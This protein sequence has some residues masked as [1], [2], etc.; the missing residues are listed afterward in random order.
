[1]VNLPQQL[2][3]PPGQPQPPSQVLPDGQQQLGQQQHQQP[4]EQQ[5][6]PLDQQ[7]PEQQQQQQ[8]QPPLHPGALHPRR[9]PSRPQTAIEQ[10]KLLTLAASATNDTAQVKKLPEI[11]PRFHASVLSLAIADELHITRTACRAI[12][13]VSHHRHLFSISRTHIADIRLPSG[14]SLCRRCHPQGHYVPY[15]QLGTAARLTSAPK[16]HDNLIAALLL[17]SNQPLDRAGELDIAIS[18]WMAARDTVAKLTCA[19]HV[20]TDWHAAFTYGVAE[21]EMAAAHPAHD[22]GTQNQAHTNLV[23]AEFLARRSHKEIMQ[24]YRHSQP[25]RRSAPAD[26]LGLPRKCARTGHLPAAC[27]AASTVTGRATASLSNDARSPHALAAPSGR[28]YCFSSSFALHST[29]CDDNMYTY[30]HG[31][32]ICGAAGHAPA[33]RLGILADWGHVVQGLR[34]G[35]DVG[36]KEQ[37]RSTTLFTNHSSTLDAAFIDSYIVGEQAAGRYSHAFDPAELE[38]LIG[39]YRTAPLG[40]VPKPHSNKFHLIQDLSFPRH[41]PFATSV[42]A[43]VNANSFPTAWGTFNDVSALLLSLPAGCMAATFDIAA[44]YPITP[45]APS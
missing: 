26:H 28:L 3:L 37:P 24:Q 42:N 41:D 2:N 11:I 10:A 1:M 9:T 34:V 14:S 32:S 17:S 15:H 4:L 18:E 16:D 38:Q 33:S 44:A 30:F 8:Q 25:G 5:Q 27:T 22:L 40:L 35:F 12:L 31:C 6:Q 29:C 36:I 43:G 19:Y 7:L 20:L 45:V 21:R 39:P 23:Q 13:P